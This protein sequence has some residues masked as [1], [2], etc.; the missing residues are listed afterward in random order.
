MKLM[1]TILP[2][3]FMIASILPASAQVRV[4]DL[5]VGEAMP[6]V[7]IKNIINSRFSSARVSHFTGKL[8]IIDFWATWCTPCIASFPKLDSLQQ[9]F[10]DKIQI[11]LV[12]DEDSTKAKRLFSRLRGEKMTSLA[13]ATGDKLLSRFFIHTTIPHY[14]WLDQNAKVIAITSGDDI[15]ETNIAA[16]IRGE[17][18]KYKLKS[19]GQVRAMTYNFLSIIPIVN[20]QTPEAGISPMKLADSTV[21]VHS[22]LTR[23]VEGMANN[24]RLAAPL[25]YGNASAV[26]MYRFALSGNSTNSINSK[27]LKI[28]IPDSSIYNKITSNLTGLEAEEWLRQNGYCYELTIPKEL[29]S[30]RFEIML[31]DLNRYFGSVF[32]IEG[33]REMRKEKCLALTR[34]SNEKKFASKGGKEK[35]E[36]DGYSIHLQNSDLKSFLVFLSKPLQLQ[37]LL[38]DETN[39][40]GKVDLELNCPLS[41]VDAI[42][43]ELEKYG[44]KFVEKEIMMS[45]PVIRM[46]N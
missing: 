17:N 40:D 37:P 25:H 29:E 5:R 2:V 11:L 10:Q 23:Y 31:G 6:D 7:E 35:A 27:H 22:V 19:E 20:L 12:T 9:K 30:R 36:M 39:Y 4:R 34:I 45:V 24:A 38:V 28:E 21:L 44:L 41:D 15:T 16:A 1:K 32:N 42:N 14:I 33:V 13:S 46:K 26:W 18:F 8:L 43:K 3:L